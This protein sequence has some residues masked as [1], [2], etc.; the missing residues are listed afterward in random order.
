[1]AMETVGL[2]SPGDMGHSIGG[3]LKANGLQVLTCLGGAQRAHPGAGGADRDSRT[4]PTSKN[5]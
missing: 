5:S 2:L 4:P 1:M 3:V